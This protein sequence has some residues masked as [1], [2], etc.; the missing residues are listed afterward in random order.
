LL[1]E[2]EPLAG[3]E[4]GVGGGGGA[5]EEEHGEGVLEGYSWGGFV[6]FGYPG[7]GG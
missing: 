6:R 4:G 3:E 5:G 2:G 1:V 7:V